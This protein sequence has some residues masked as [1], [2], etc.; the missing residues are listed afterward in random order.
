MFLIISEIYLF[1]F[2]THVTLGLFF[3]KSQRLSVTNYNYLEIENIFAIK[4]STYNYRT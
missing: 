1:L 3:L 4:T 2:R